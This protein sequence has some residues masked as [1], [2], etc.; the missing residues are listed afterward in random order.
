LRKD[1]NQWSFVVKWKTRV[2]T[3]LAAAAAVVAVVSYSYTSA[4]RVVTDRKARDTL[5]V[6]TSAVKTSVSR[7][8]QQRPV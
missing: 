8:L 1:V 2:V 6:M 5:A 7:A 3:Q 4:R